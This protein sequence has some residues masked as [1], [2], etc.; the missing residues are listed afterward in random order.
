MHSSIGSSI[1]LTRPN[2]TGW[3]VS[4]EV[5]TESYTTSNSNLDVFI[6][7][8]PNQMSYEMQFQI[9]PFGDVNNH[10]DFYSDDAPLKATHRRDSNR[11]FR[12]SML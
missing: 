5:R 4:P 6:E 8:L 9:N 3:V 2:K 11:S 1:N 7:N 12:L 10:G